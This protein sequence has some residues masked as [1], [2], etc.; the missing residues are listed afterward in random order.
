MSSG[1][2]LLLI[3]VALLPLSVYAQEAVKYNVKGTILEE[4]K[5]ES[6]PLAFSTIYVSGE[7]G[8][9]AARVS[10]HDDGSFSFHLADGSYKMLV[11]STGHKSR[12]I[13]L[14]ISGKDVDL[15]KIYLKIGEEIA[16]ASI[17]GES[18]IKR[19]G[20]RVV[21]DVS[22]DPEAGKIDMAKMI[23]KIP[24][25]RISHRNG[26]IVMDELPLADIYVNR[27]NSG[28]INANRQHP[29]KFIKANYMKEVELV[30][31]GDLEY[32]NDK[33]ILLIKLARKL[34]Y[35]FSGQIETR[36]DTKKS[37]YSSTDVVANTP[38]IG[39][40]A[41][42]SYQH[43]GAPALTDET[44]REITDSSSSV[45]RTES[46]STSW[47]KAN[48]HSVGLD[49]FRQ[50]AKNRIN[51][52]A[53]VDGHF[54]EGTSA[55]ESKYVVYK[56]DAST[57]SDISK[58]SGSSK[59]PF[60]VN[61]R[62]RLGGSFGKPLGKI[63]NRRKNEWNLAYSFQDNYDEQENI[64]P[65][66]KL[67][68]S[69]G[70]Q[71]HRAIGSL[72]L[73]DPINKPI[74]S[75][76]K[77]S[78]GY[79]DRLYDI[80][81]DSREY[82]NGLDYRQQVAFLDLTTLGKAFKGKLGYTLMLR[83]EYLGNKGDFL[84]GTVISPLDYHA[85][86]L[87]PMVVFAWYPK[88]KVLQFLYASNVNRP[89]VNQLNPYEDRSDPYNIRTGNPSLKGSKT[90]VFSFSFTNSPVPKW[91]SN[92]NLSLSY[93]NMT[94]GIERMVSVQDDGISRSTYQNIGQSESFFFR[95]DAKIRLTKII[96][97]RVMASYGKSFHTFSSGKKNSIGSPSASISFS[98]SPDWLDI[99]ASLLLK[100]S[101]QSVQLSK[102]K[103]EPVS[104]ISVSHYFEKPKLHLSFEISDV[105]HRGGLMESTIHSDNFV[106]QNYR[107]RIGRCYMIGLCWVFG[108]YKESSTKVVEAYDF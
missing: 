57:I 39:V 64:Y 3:C 15:G 92:Y 40:G 107:E 60:K 80:Y 22:K 44:I 49:A 35:G 21:Y 1:K 84:N 102:F 88:R 95:G 47:S 26:K 106:Q 89:K 85:F 100:Q 46:E 75:A 105:L 31:P 41:S 91:I 51:F 81:T 65:T 79:Y 12:I 90:D 30:L 45:T 52:N 6:V 16:A 98:A 61:A 50:F 72:S 68:S 74:I 69:S 77:I 4:R 11:E 29:M 96:S 10:N 83:A 56:S 86:N 48:S 8:S 54:S 43:Q 94:G 71:E 25:L 37:V 103:M 14:N 78:L 93:S 108:R 18:L 82:T 70:S 5:K 63:G 28:L 9:L 17:E 7:D 73:R 59:S 13:K 58:V 42:Y 55:S 38:W 33:P 66:Y 19:N 53:S 32:N 36:A 97:T 27:N 87:S 2:I 101:A 67:F 24:E 23:T 62:V 34:P 104:S 76:S 20:T 99:N